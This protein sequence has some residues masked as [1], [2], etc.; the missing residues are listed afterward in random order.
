VLIAIGIG[1]NREKT[2]KEEEEVD[3][4]I[5]ASGVYSIFKK[6]PREDLTKIRPNVEE[7]RKYLEAQSE[8]SGVQL[9]EADKIALIEQW[10]SSIS[11]NIRIIEKG[12]LEGVDLYFYNY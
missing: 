6:S 8:I 3:P 5:H 10:N 12:D 4:I 9:T 7:I 2:E 11:E 1:F